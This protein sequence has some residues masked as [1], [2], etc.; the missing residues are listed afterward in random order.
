M[1]KK[2]IT[3]TDYDGNQRTEEFYFN[4]NKAELVEME[5]STQGGL[6]ALIKK[7]VAEQDT[8]RIIAIFKDIICRAYGEKSLDGKHFRKSPE[9]TS[10]FVQTEAYSELFM[11]LATDA[12]A[13]A[14]FINGIIPADARSAKPT[15][16][17]SAK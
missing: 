4:L 14:A 11:E 10:D 3:Y 5:M 9:L 13:A 2:E 12:D 1:L 16:I 15:P 17:P 8:S 7:I 6:E